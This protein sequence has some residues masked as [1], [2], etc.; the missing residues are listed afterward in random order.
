M[1]SEESYWVDVTVTQSM[2][3]DLARPGSCPLDTPWGGGEEP[4]HEKSAGQK[5]FR[6]HDR[7]PYNAMEG[8]PINELVFNKWDMSSCV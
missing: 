2:Y 5:V 3:I 4:E 8:S 7:F 6:A 1:E